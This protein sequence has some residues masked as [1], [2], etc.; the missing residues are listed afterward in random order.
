MARL[1]PAGTELLYESIQPDMDAPRSIFSIPLTG[2]APWL[3]LRDKYIVN[4]QC[5]QLPSALCLYD[6]STPS[7]DS[8]RR[9]DPSTGE[10]SPLTEIS[11][12]GALIDWTLSP[13]GSQLAIIPYSP[14]QNV[15]QLRSTSD[16]TNR[17]LVVKGRVG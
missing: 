14:E 7:K 10:S 17:D 1:N 9:F 15:I 6:V 4:L 3:V 16:N 11:A 2:G 12:H 5:A 13:N 8:I